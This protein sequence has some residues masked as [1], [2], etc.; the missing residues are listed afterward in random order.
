M[1]VHE[2]FAIY[3]IEEI[4]KNLQ[5]M[6]KVL[7]SLGQ[8]DIIFSG[9]YELDFQTVIRETAATI[10]KLNVRDTVKDYLSYSLANFAHSPYMAT[11]PIF[12]QKIKKTHEMIKCIQDANYDTQLITGEML[13]R[14]V[15]FGTYDNITKRMN[16]ILPPEVCGKHFDA[17][18]NITSEELVK[19]V[20]EYLKKYLDSDFE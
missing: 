2:K 15:S 8:K 18:S 12:R 1:S 16:K 7:E 19:K 10:N 9:E 17:P 3:S 11:T 5:G 14:A 20:P 13:R 4:H 6:D